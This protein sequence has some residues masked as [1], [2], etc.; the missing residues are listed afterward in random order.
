[1]TRSVAETEPIF[2][3]DGDAYVPTGHARG[4]WDPDM[5]HGG[6]PSALLAGAF[7]ALAPDLQLARLTVEFF[8]A[9]PL[10]PLTIAAEVVKP[11]RRLQLAEATLTAGGRET[12]RARAVLL[13][14]TELDGL[15]EGTAGA[16]LDRGPEE[17]EPIAFPLSHQLDGFGATAMDLRFTDGSWGDGPARVWFRLKR[18]LVEGEEPTPVQRAVAAADFGNGVSRVLHWDDWLFINTDLTVQLHRP[19]AGEW[20]ALDAR[21]ILE[22]NG[23]GLAVSTLHDRRGPIGT[24]QQ[25]LFVDRR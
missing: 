4:P 6:A 19:P 13:R 12:C 25:T 2:R 17:I 8:G 10:V 5:Q 14:R 16:P 9:V 24:G 21:T 22:P 1:M 7:E 11:G 15:P 23:S 18:P 3:R 20:V